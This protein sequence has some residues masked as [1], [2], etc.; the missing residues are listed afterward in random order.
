MKLFSLFSCFSTCFLAKPLFPDPEGPE[1]RRRARRM[2]SGQ[3]A[4]LCLLLSLAGADAR[5]FVFQQQTDLLEQGPLIPQAGWAQQ[6]EGTVSPMVGDFLGKQAVFAPRVAGS[7]PLVSA[8]FQL[9]IVQHWKAGTEFTLEFDV[10]VGEN[11]EGST[12]AVGLGSTVGGIP[13][14]IEINGNRLSIRQRHFG[15]ALFA[16]DQEGDN[17]CVEPDKWLRVK[18]VF[19]KKSEEEVPTV[20]VTLEDESSG[21]E[22]A[23]FF[24]SSGMLLPE[25]PIAEDADAP[26]FAYVN[27]IWI[28]VQG[29]GAIRNIVISR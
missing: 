28:R 14:Q 4:V 23:A 1:W 19:R 17:I 12:A 29:T 3:A 7:S 16:H 15:N 9:P 22:T 10:A 8:V 26:L 5:S 6:S 11:F 21:K 2:A 25:H 13:A 20:A 24:G 27:Q 18:A